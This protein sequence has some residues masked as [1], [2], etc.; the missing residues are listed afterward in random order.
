MVQAGNACRWCFVVVVLAFAA[1]S[2][3]QA[4]VHLR[5]LSHLI[6]SNLCRVVCVFAEKIRSAVAWH[7]RPT[8]STSTSCA[9]RTRRHPACP[10]TLISS[11]LHHQTVAVRP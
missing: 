11:F 8:T 3:L 5:N 2:D 6:C 1:S 7:N 10:A 4:D 9:I